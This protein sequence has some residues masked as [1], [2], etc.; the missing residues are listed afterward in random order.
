[1][2]EKVTGKSSHVLAY[3][4]VLLVVVSLLSLT[5]FISQLVLSSGTLSSRWFSREMLYLQLSLLTILLPNVVFCSYLSWGLKLTS[6]FYRA[7]L[8]AAAI[9]ILPIFPAGFL[10]G[11]Y[12]LRLRHTDDDAPKIKSRPKAAMFS[13][14]DQFT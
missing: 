5:L 1:M 14:G 6:R 7:S 11:F 4:G 9:V 10:L 2:S 13:Y 3:F 12:L 8:V